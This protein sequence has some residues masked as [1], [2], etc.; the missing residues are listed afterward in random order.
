MKLGRQESVLFWPSLRTSNTENQPRVSS[1]HFPRFTSPSLRAGAGSAIEVSGL[2]VSHRARH[3]WA[4]QRHPLITCRIQRPFAPKRGGVVA[5]CSMTHAQR[6]Q[7][8]CVTA[9]PWVEM[10]SYLESVFIEFLV[11]NTKQGASCCLNDSTGVNNAF[12]FPC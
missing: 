4:G 6:G 8:V 11:Q 5:V 9:S 1:A 7:H 10:E 12:S 2:S 3:T